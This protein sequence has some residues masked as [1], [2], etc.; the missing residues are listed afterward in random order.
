MKRTLTRKVIYK[1]KT[2]YFNLILSGCFIVIS[3]AAVVGLVYNGILHEYTLQAWVFN[4]LLS[5]GM[6]ALFTYHIGIRNI[7]KIL[8]DRKAAYSDDLVIIE[9]V[10]KEMFSLGANTNEDGK[11]AVLV[12]EKGSNL[13]NDK[14]FVYGSTMFH[15][16]VGDHYYLVFHNIH[17]KEPLGYYKVDDWNLS[18]EL[19]DRVRSV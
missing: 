2:D 7:R 8:K 19:Q 1:H 11:D 14:L 12:F 10:V 6:I 18:K 15:T 9:G 4:M 17:R 13:K 5:A 16:E 3:L